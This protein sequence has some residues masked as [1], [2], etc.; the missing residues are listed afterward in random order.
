MANGYGNGYGGGGIAPAG[1]AG[2][3]FN[4]SFYK[5]SGNREIEAPFDLGSGR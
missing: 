3:R 4:F 5:E 2:S 1:G